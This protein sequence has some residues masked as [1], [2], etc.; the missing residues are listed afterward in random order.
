MLCTGWSAM[1]LPCSAPF[2]PESQ[3]HVSFRDALSESVSKLAATYRSEAATTV[4][5]KI[6]PLVFEKFQNLAHS[7][8]EELKEKD[9]AEN[10]ARRILGNT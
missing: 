1:P 9:E 6:T 5:S 3:R 8:D 2:A 4:Q 7:Y 10:E